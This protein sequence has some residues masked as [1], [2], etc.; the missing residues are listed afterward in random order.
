MTSVLSSPALTWLIVGAYLL[1][2]VAWAAVIG[3]AFVKTGAPPAW[4]YVTGGALAG[5]GFA[6]L[7][8]A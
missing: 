6:P 4:M 1:L 7:P 5:A 8:F 2:I 3:Y